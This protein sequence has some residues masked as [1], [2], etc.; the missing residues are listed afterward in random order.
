IE[1]VLEQS[2]ENPEILGEWA[3]ALHADVRP[4]T[5]RAI[6]QDAYERITATAKAKPARPVT[7]RRAALAP[8]TPPPEAPIFQMGVPLDGITIHPDDKKFETVGDADGWAAYALLPAIGAPH[9]TMR[10]V[11]RRPDDFVYDLERRDGLA[12]GVGRPIRVGL[13]GDFG[14]GLP[15]SV[16]IA[17]LLTHAHELDCAI[18]VGDVYYAGRPDEWNDGMLTPLALLMT[19]T[20][21]FWLNANHE[22]YGG[23]ERYE[24]MLGVKR[25]IAP[26]LQPQEA[27]T[28]VLRGTHWQIVGIDTAYPVNGRLSDEDG[29]KRAE[30]LE[31]QLVAGRAQGLQTILLSQHEPFRLGVKELGDLHQDVRRACGSKSVHDEIAFW[32]WG[33]EH[34][35]ALFAP[36]PDR[37]VPFVGSCIGH[38]GYPYYRTD[39]EFTAIASR[40][41]D[42][43]EGVITAARR[44]QRSRAVPAP[45]VWYESAPRFPAGAGGKR[46]RPGMGNN[47]YCVLELHPAG[48]VL[49]YYDWLGWRRYRTAWSRA[50]GLHDAEEF[51]RP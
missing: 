24:H 45:L 5:A 33:D 25:L 7:A 16:C 44:H 19:R 12:S 8:W 13:F 9:G 46:P 6:L 28:F 4:Q 41:R 51:P 15:H 18:H 11:P 27:S 32:F 40:F 14:T 22:M 31:A 39:H 47:G 43:L 35:A 48:L 17:R 34:Y 37:N 26:S 1:A 30:W 50:D 36:N 38:G 49:E 42:E 23:A 10:K 29:A 3:R 21:V 2:K 20:P